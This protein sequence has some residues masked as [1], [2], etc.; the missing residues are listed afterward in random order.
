MHSLLRPQCVGLLAE[1]SFTCDDKGDVTL[2]WK[3]M[4]KKSRSK[5]SLDFLPLIG[6][7]VKAQRQRALMR[8]VKRNIQSVCDT[9]DI[10]TQAVSAVFVD[11]NNA[12]EQTGLM[13]FQLPIVDDVKGLFLKLTMLDEGSNEPLRS[14]TLKVL[15]DQ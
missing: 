6:R 8:T 9:V 7:Y 15:K 1:G 3:K 10:H 5:S 13:K 11:Q 4:L 14:L 2:T 12:P